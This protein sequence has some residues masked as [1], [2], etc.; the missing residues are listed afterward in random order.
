[1]RIPFLDRFVTKSKSFYEMEE[2]TDKT[3]REYLRSPWED[4]QQIGQAIYADENKTRTVVEAMECTL[5]VFCRIVERIRKGEEDERIVRETGVILPYIAA[6]REIAGRQQP[7]D[8][9]GT[10]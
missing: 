10:E 3:L 4:Y 5:P 2:I 1:M 8:V 6:L 7:E 9:N